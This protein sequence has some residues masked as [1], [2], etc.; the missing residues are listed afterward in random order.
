MSSVHRK[1][2]VGRHADTTAGE[3]NFEHVGQVVSARF[4]HCEV[5]LFLFNN[6]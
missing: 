6:Y 3:V 2:G 5:T 4:L 1:E